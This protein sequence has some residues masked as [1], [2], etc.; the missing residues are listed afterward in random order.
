MVKRVSAK[1]MRRA[2]APY[3]HTELMKQDWVSRHVSLGNLRNNDLEMYCMMQKDFLSPA[4]ALH[5]IATGRRSYSIHVLIPLGY[6]PLRQMTLRKLF[7]KQCRCH[8]H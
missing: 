7:Q 4:E 5:G 2:H 6:A 1:F 3:M 8:K